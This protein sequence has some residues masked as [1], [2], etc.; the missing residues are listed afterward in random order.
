MQIESDE[1][2][3]FYSPQNPGPNIMQVFHTSEGKISSEPVKI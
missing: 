1:L 2:K 3:R